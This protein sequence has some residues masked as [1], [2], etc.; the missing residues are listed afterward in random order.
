MPGVKRIMAHIP[1]I[2]PPPSGH[3]PPPP[4]RAPPGTL[5]APGQGRRRLP[6]WRCPKKTKALARQKRPDSN[7][8]GDH[9]TGESKEAPPAAN[10][11]RPLESRE[12]TA[13]PLP[14][15]RPIPRGWNC[16]HRKAYRVSKGRALWS[17]EPF[18]MPQVRNGPWIKILHK[19]MASFLHPDTFISKKIIFPI[20]RQQHKNRCLSTRG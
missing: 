15:A 19:K 3:L 7:P 12:E 4:Q 11:L 14:E 18:P 10:G 9:G 2:I 8:G 16:D 6:A 5:P 1:W 13:A 17:P 20:F